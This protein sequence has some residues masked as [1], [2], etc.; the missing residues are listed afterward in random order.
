M[1]SGVPHPG[2]R[3][4]LRATLS[5]DSKYRLKWTVEQRPDTPGASWRPYKG[6]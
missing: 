3:I 6:G 5:I 4:W 2:A 1:P